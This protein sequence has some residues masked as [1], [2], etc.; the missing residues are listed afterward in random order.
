MVLSEDGASWI[1]PHRLDSVLNTDRQSK[2]TGDV[3]GRLQHTI[4]P[5]SNYYRETYSFGGPDG[6]THYHASAAAVCEMFEE[7]A[8]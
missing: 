7:A 3:Y 4:P 5:H 1:F 6:L 2:L 8:G